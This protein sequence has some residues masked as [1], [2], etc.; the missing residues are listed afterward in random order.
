MEY[1]LFQLENG[2]RLVHHHVDTPVAYLGLIINTGS[3]DE[4]DDE[5]GLAHFIEHTV[6]KGTKNRKS[7]HILNRLSVVG[8][9]INA[10]TTKEETCIHATFLRDYYDRAIELLSDIVL[11]STFPEKELE[12][13]KGV[14]I[15]EINSY[16]DSPGEQIFDDF[17]ELIF[18]GHSIGKNIL[19]T[20][21]SVR[22]FSEKNIRKFIN[23]NYS[24]EGMVIASVGNMKFEKVKY[25]VEKY[26]SKLPY[27]S[28]NSE[29]VRFKEYKPQNVVLEKNIYQT[30]CLM[31]NIAYDVHNDNKLTLAMINNLL[32]GPVM[33]SRL[34]M[35]LREKYGYAYNVESVY[36]AYSDIGVI[37]I[38]FGTDK[39]NKEKSFELVK[40]ELDKF[41]NKKMGVLQLQNAK[42]QITG[43]L[44]M[45][46][47]SKESLMLTMGKSIL[48]FNKVDSF[49]YIRKKVES[50][51]A[52]K[53]LEVANEVLNFEDFSTLVFQQKK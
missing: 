33:N 51:T 32:G 14:I 26:F 52:E 17:E 4:N 12:K 5:R 43:Q 3:R 50:I 28:D 44:A 23:N 29:R 36:T 34:N 38:Y 13:E 35:S 1:K 20:K 2:I 21:K 22:K 47:E 6:F 25:I 11:N 27:R 40:K 48:L 45:A 39:E 37:D 8:G 30:H 19:G 31:G 46:N 42:K 9:D 53:I 41:L 49:E 16:K 10:Y 7:H 24:T 18:K 15:D